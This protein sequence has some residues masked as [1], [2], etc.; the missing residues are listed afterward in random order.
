[1]AETGLPI[2][3]VE[4]LPRN[5]GFARARLWRKRN[6][7]LYQGDSR[8]VLRKLFAGKLRSLRG[9]IVFAYL[10]AHWNADL[11]LREEL[12]LIFSHCPAA[13]VMIDDFQVPDD[14][15]YQYDDYGAGKS[16]SPAYIGPVLAAY[17]LAAYYPSTP[18][19]AETGAK[20]GCVGLVNK[21]SHDDLLR[22]LP[23]LRRCAEESNVAPERA[24]L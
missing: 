18:S 19:S 3:S 22:G 5:Y 16:L 11:P 9:Q 10:D 17:D 24:L 23:L 1:M 8:Q 2:Y 15:G 12:E 14:P 21:H 7:Y 6:V 13:V 20:R 4:G